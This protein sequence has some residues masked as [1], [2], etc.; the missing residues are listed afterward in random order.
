VRGRVRERRVPNVAS[1]AEMDCVGWVNTAWIEA[2]LPTCRWNSTP[3]GLATRRQLREL[4]LCPG[5]HGPVA[6]LHCRPGGWLHAW[7]YRLDLATEKRAATPAVLAALEAAMRARRTCPT[8]ERD[9]GCCI[10][11]SLGECWD[12]HQGARARVAAQHPGHIEA[13]AAAGWAV[14]A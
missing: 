6:A 14:A 8:C 11:R 5:G 9:M 13:A 1:G 10:P 12:C 3:A 4:G 7:L 2:G